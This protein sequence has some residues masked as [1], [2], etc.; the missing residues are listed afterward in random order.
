GNTGNAGRPIIS[1]RPVRVPSAVS[2]CAPLH[3]ERQLPAVFHAHQHGVI[4]ALSWMAEESYVAP[5][6]ISE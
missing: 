5:V 1:K 6:A 4:R 3:A 2:G